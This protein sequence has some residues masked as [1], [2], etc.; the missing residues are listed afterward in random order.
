[1]NLKLQ[2]KTPDRPQQSPSNHKE[3]HDSPLP[4][5]AVGS[6]APSSGNQRRS[7]RGRGWAFSKAAEEVSEV[8][9]C[10]ASGGHEG[11]GASEKH[12][13]ASAFTRE[14]FYDKYPELTRR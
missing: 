9:A 11:G 14:A 4:D 10:F 8:R 1:M 6:Q 5:E 3:N 7:E 2:V 12:T 13:T